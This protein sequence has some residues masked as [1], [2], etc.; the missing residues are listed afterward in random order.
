M[1]YAKSVLLPGHANWEINAALSLQCVCV[2]GG[3]EGR[4]ESVEKPKK[5]KR[6]KRTDN[7]SLRET[8]RSDV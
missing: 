6:N 3:G 5:G 8:V 2:G 7:T 1:L 4:R